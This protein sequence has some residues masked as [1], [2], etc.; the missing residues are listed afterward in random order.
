MKKLGL[1]SEHELKGATDNKHVCSQ[2]AM[3]TLPLNGREGTAVQIRDSLLG[4][5]S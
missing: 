1:I 5:E 4:K 2:N 3:K